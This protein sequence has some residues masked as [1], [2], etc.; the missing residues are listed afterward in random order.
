MGT[1]GGEAGASDVATADT[2]ALP[3]AIGDYRAR[4]RAVD[5]LRLPAYAGSAWRGIFGRALRRAVCV[6]GSRSCEGCMLRGNC[7]YAYL[8][9]TPPPADAKMLRRYPAAPHPF[10]VAPDDKAA[11]EIGEGQLFH[12]PFRL[13]GQGNAHLPYVVHALQRAGGYGIGRG[14]GRFALEGVEQMGPGGWQAI[15][16]ADDGGLAP[17][18][19]GPALVPPPPNDEVRLVMETP[20]RAKR[21]G[22]LVGPQEF[23]FHDLFRTLLRRL[24]ALCHFHG[25]QCLEVDFRGLVEQARGVVERTGALRWHEWT[26][27][28]SRQRTT[29]QMGGLLGEVTYAGPDLA[30]FWP[31][32]WAGQW[33]HAGKA[34]SM[35]LGRYRLAAASL[36]AT[37]HQP[38]AG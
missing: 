21:A 32:L 4:L 6:T 37:C 33:T 22:A 26:R 38:P 30:P 20:L 9:E 28:S 8:F 31:L 11:G 2:Q 19:A 10:L 24:S 34:A 36:P 25:D 3:L 23:A 14:D 35:G 5:A 12:L 7:A 27:Y 13:F 15:M 17:A 29:M 16:P 1:T 18:P